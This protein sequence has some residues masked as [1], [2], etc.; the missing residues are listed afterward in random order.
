MEI[1]E[2]TDTDLIKM[3]IEIELIGNIAIKESKKENK[4]KGVPL[5]YSIDGKILKQNIKSVIIRTKSTGSID[6]DGNVILSKL[7]G[8]Y[9][10]DKKEDS[11]NDK[12]EIRKKK[13][14]SL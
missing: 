1:K 5:V 9:A 13:L 12:F 10:I 2:F 8:F 11:F 4:L 3:S 7:C 14:H 6:N